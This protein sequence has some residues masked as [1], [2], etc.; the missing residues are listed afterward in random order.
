MGKQRACGETSSE[1]ILHAATR[2]RLSG[3]FIP[4][5][6]RAMLSLK[7]DRARMLSRRF[8][9]RA[10]PGDTLC[11]FAGMSFAVVGI[12]G[13]FSKTVLL[14]FIPQIFNFVLSCPQLFGL[15]ECPRHRM[16][17]CVLFPAFPLF[18]PAYNVISSHLVWL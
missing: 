8:P 3:L 10:F 4:Q 2:W 15:V 11:Y 7:R 18:P 6:V 14:F 9:A 5:L 17:Q 13:H 16:P 1:F 12:L